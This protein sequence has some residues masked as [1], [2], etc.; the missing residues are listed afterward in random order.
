MELAEELKRSPCVWAGGS[1]REV[2][3]KHEEAYQAM[4]ERGQH[5]LK[6]RLYHSRDLSPMTEYDFVCLEV[7]LNNYSEVHKVM[8]VTDQVLTINSYL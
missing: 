5:P 7:L 1:H 6:V 4:A 2:P 3:I 8:S